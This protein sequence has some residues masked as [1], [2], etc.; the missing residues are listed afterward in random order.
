MSVPCN[1][2]STTNSHVAKRMDDRDKV[3]SVEARDFALRDVASVN[4]RRL[5]CGRLTLQ[6]LP[7]LL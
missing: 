5:A 6:S 1:I 7:D 2:S 3:I 4:A